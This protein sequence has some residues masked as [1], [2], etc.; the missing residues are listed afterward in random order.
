MRRGLGWNK[1]DPELGKLEIEARIFGD[2]LTFHRQRARFEE[3]EEFKPTEEDWD[4]ANMHALNK[5]NR[6]KLQER[7]LKVFQA[8]GRKGIN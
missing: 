5:F 3:W 1:K 4:V 7:H 6:G 8:R 2:K